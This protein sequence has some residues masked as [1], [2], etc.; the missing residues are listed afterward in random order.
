[1]SSTA[2]SSGF[3]ASRSRRWD[4][5]LGS[6]LVVPAA[7][8]RCRF[9]ITACFSVKPLLG[10]LFEPAFKVRRPCRVTG[11]RRA[12]NLNATQ[13]AGRHITAQSRRGHHQRIRGLGA[14]RGR[15][16][17]AHGVL[18]FPIYFVMRHRNAPSATGFWKKQP[19]Y[20]VEA[21][22]GQDT[23]NYKLCRTTAVNSRATV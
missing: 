23:G 21:S 20:G 2:S 7:D 15:G 10:L 3:R 18:Y 9:T 19:Q 17:R 5:R 11:A 8:A 12:I 1:M 14:P 4:A 6:L 22:L 16:M 13:P